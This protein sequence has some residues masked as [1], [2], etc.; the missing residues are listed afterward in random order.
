MVNVHAPSGKKSLQDAQRK[1]LLTNLLQSSSQNAWQHQFRPSGNIGN[2]HFLIGG[3]MNTTPLQMSYLLQKCLDNGLLRTK[4]RI[5]ERIFAK[6]G[7]LCVVGGLQASTLTTTAPNH[8]RLHEPHG[9]C[10]SPMRQ[11]SAT[12]Q[13]SSIRP[14]KQQSAAPSSGYAT[15]QS[16]T[17]LSAQA[18]WPRHQTASS[19]SSVWDQP[20][21]APA[22]GSAMEQPLPARP[23][24]PPPPP[25]P[26]PPPLP[27]I[28]ATEHSEETTKRGDIFQSEDFL[29][30]LQEEAAAPPAAVATEHSEETTNLPAQ[31]RLT[32]SIVNAFFNNIT[33]ASGSAE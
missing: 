12:E 14:G 1:T 25:P 2:A 18:S 24:P 15:E 9:I 33:F 10:W 7:D 4:A 30:D 6:H 20:L 28:Q 22:G 29:Q 27:A 3:D 31:K 23:P 8:D 5:H 17:A 19:S 21:A 32:Y 26:T 11:R 13:P 16:L